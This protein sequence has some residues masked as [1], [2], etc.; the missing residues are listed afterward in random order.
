MFFRE[1]GV[2]TVPGT[3]L[4]QDHPGEKS[5][6]SSFHKWRTSLGRLLVS[7]GK[8]APEPAGQEGPQARRHRLS[9]R[10]A[11]QGRPP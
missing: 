7:G 11:V 10:K 1:S 2:G 9:W 5:L 3:A 4:S 8:G 6:F